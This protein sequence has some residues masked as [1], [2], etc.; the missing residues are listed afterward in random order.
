MGKAFL[1]VRH[2]P[3]RIVAGA[4]AALL[5]LWAGNASAFDP[6]LP[7]EPVVKELAPGVFQYINANGRWNSGFVVGSDSV[8]VIDAMLT[9]AD[10]RK[11]LA[12]IRKRTDK[13]VRYL[14]ITHQHSDHYFGAQVYVPPAELIAHEAVRHHYSRNLEKEFRFRKT[15]SPKADLSEV[16]VVLPTMTI[17]GEGKRMTLHLGGKD[18]DIHNY[19][20]G[21]TPDALF[22]HVP[23]DRILF[24]GDVFNRKSINYMAGAP[25]LD[26][27]F[28]IL[29]RIEAID[30][31]IYAGG[32]GLPAGKED[33]RAYR[34][35]LKDF[36]D[37]V[38]GAIASGLS[39]ERAAAQI[40]LPQYKGWRNYENFTRRNVIGLYKRFQ[41]EAKRK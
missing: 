3:R 32:H 13:P 27:W 41:R 36:I 28:R 30:A 34:Q 1:S 10:A 22:I 33:F 40:T 37:G 25:S 23:A 21:Q 18:I 2:T 19:G 7:K 17:A 35:M 39:V 29:D 4:V 8:A 12:E 16:K 38:K 26:G 11:V 15:V 6:E 5:C 24:T 31:T 9:P 14:I 20:V